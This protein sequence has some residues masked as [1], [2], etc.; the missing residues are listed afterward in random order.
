MSEAEHFILPAHNEQVASEVLTF[1]ISSQLGPTWQQQRL[2]LF[3]RGLTIVFLCSLL[4]GSETSSFITAVRLQ[5]MPF[6]T[7][8]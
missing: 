3:L 6:D 5:P 4:H 2:W 7:R 1:S 8:Q